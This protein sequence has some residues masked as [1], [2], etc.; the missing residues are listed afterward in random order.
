MKGDIW[1]VSGEELLRDH[2]VID[3][4]RITIDADPKSLPTPEI[5]S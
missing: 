3:A 4:V 1:T 2:T 5:D